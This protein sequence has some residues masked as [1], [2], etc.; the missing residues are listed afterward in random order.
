MARW[1]P[2]LA[3]LFLLVPLGL[4]A[5]PPATSGQAPAVAPF[6]WR[7]NWTGRYPQADPPLHWGRQPHS[8]VETLRSALASESETKDALP[9]HKGLVRQWLLL[10]PVATADTDASRNIDKEHVPD[11][12]DLAGADGASAAGVAWKALTLPVNP[13][14]EEWGRAGLEWIDLA[15]LFPY[16]PNQLAYACTYLHSP[17]AQAV[18]LAFEHGQGLKLWLNG[19]P[20]YSHPRQAGAL[21]TYAA[22]SRFKQ[23]L[24]HAPSPRVRLDLRAGWNR[25]LLK[26]ATWPHPGQAN[27]GFVVRLM[28]AGPV[29]YDDTNIAW[30]ADLGERT[31][32]APLVIGD[33]VITPAEPDE[34]VCLDKRTG[35]VLWRRVVGFQDT[36]SEAER[37]APACRE[38][39]A[40]AVAA[41][42]AGADYLAALA[43]RRQVR[44]ALESIDER[45]FKLRWDGH[46]ASHFA[47]VG[48]TTTPVSDGRH[49][50]AFFGNGMVACFDL[51]GRRRWSVRLATPE[52]AYSCSPALVGGRL[53]VVFDGL[54][55]LDAATG[56]QL[57][58]NKDAASI[59]S[60]IPARIA[61]TDVVFT[62]KGHGFRVSDG[63]RVWQHPSIR[64]GNGG[65]AAPLVQ[66]G[67]MYLPW[68]G[69]GELMVADFSQTRDE[70]WQARTRHI[71]LKANHRR[72]S[73]EWL[74]RSTAGSPVVHEGTYYN[75]DQYGV[76]YAVDLATGNT[77]YT[78]DAGFD[79]LHHYNAI[80]VGASPT[81]AGKHL[82][83]L[84]N[85]GVCVVVEL[86]PRCKV[87]AV[88]RIR[89]LLHRDWP[90]GAQ[91]LLANA[92]PVFD[93]RRM[94]V[95]GERYL[96]CIGAR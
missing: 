4:H 38:K 29:R 45:R 10:G 67:V 8:A 56:R 95:R 44:D 18:D 71:G 42:E 58:H 20:L 12:A 84:D 50:W 26:V 60:L 22:L 5:D 81:L 24:T 52:I 70:P 11:E 28:D 83:L 93:G 73:G 59:A 88:N 54:R 62:Q 21:G 15:E 7:G 68:G 78:H 57:W 3:S 34:L 72:P 76:L 25:L 31:N 89:T 87:T 17:K 48:F 46:L 66:D 94:Y 30:V 27:W 55:G 53:M 86:G 85:Q 82:F 14:Y 79:E 40:P 33:R 49:V 2:S 23:N 77:L 91:E 43:L 96:Y 6:G 19:R 32:A 37:A 35:R 63:Q 47:I 36:L 64:T 90:I 74:D 16:K 13:D 75:I 1:G 80:G 69:V 65:W 61:D 92:P 9:I 41:L 51:K 39:I